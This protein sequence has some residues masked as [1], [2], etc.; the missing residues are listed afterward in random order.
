MILWF[1]QLLLYQSNF[2]INVEMF[3]EQIID[4]SQD[5]D[6]LNSVLPSFALDSF[7]STKTSA[8]VF[9]VYE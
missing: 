6:T 8:F 5:D 7:F 2:S 9:S 1:L 4:V 3:D